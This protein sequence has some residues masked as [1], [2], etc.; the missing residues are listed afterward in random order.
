MNREP[1]ERI[2]P[3]TTDASL[4]GREKFRKGDRVQLSE[5]GLAHFGQRR[6]PHTGVVI[7]FGRQSHQ[8]RI[9]RDGVKNPENYHCK[10]WDKVYP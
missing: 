4:S 6:K 9:V 7:G 5:E 2:I 8:V 10:F 3:M 1:T